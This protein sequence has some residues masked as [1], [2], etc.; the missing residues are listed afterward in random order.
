MNNIK[1]LLYSLMM[2]LIS[3]SIYAQD[4]MTIDNDYQNSES[5]WR[6]IISP[7]AWLAG[8]ATDAGGA[9][10]RQSFK[11]LASLTNSGFQLK[12][13]V[14]Y[15]KWLVTADGTY[16]NL[17]SSVDQDILKVDLDI[18]QYILDFKLEYLVYSDIDMDDEAEVI[19]GWDF[20][21]NAGGKYWRNDIT[22]DYIIQIGDPP[23]EGGFNELQTWWDPMLGV[24]ARLYLSDWVM[25]GVS[26]NWGGFGIG[27]ASKFAWDFTYVNTFKVSD[28]ISVT[29]GYR[30]FKYT[31]VDGEGDD[32]L[33]TTVTAFGPLLGVSFIF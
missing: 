16:A 12:A 28:L 6:F 30:Q 5:D 2:L 31:R 18:K 26:A 22:V 21:I 1:I 9:K 4:K 20:G 19:R 29:A 3:S 32:K 23:E 14:I 13:T 7:Y 24:N 15:K 33:E 11:D 10:M 27:N 8:Q 17:G 25:A